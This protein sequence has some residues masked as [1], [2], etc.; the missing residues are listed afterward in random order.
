MLSDAAADNAA[1][2]AAACESS[3]DDRAK[4]LATVDAHHSDSDS[5]PE[6][7]LGFKMFCWV[8]RWPN[9]PS[10]MLKAV[11][12][13]ASYTL[14][15][16]EYLVSFGPPV[17]EGVTLEWTHGK[18]TL[19]RNTNA[20]NF[21]GVHPHPVLKVSDN[22]RPMA[23]DVGNVVG[24]FIYARRASPYFF[25]NDSNISKLQ[26]YIQ[27]LNTTFKFSKLHSTYNSTL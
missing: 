16:V 4:W 6:P 1:A 5:E 10:N 13:R 12:L 11:P 3:K 21:L 7:I 18:R 23:V 22:R 27:I 24:V 15:D 9:G 25:G 20:V 14:K 2:D 26:T 8:P 19:P 17:P